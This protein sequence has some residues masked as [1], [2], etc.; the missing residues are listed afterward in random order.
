[1]GVTMPSRYP[2]MLVTVR[3]IWGFSFLL[4]DIKRINN[5]YTYSG[6]VT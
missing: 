3:V 2:V 5:I 4:P 6:Y 1:M